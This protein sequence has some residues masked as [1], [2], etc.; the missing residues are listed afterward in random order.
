MKEKFVGE[1]L[2]PFEQNPLTKR[3]CRDCGVTLRTHRYFNCVECTPE[4]NCDDDFIY[5][6]F[7]NAKADGEE[8]GDLWSGVDT[9]KFVTS[10]GSQ[11]LTKEE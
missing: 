10:H 7:G 1:S 5:D 2:V 4:A 11:W 8:P 9:S 6:A 3:K